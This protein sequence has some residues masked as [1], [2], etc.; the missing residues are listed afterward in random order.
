MPVMCVHVG[1]VQQ[2]HMRVQ[3]YVARGEPV[4]VTSV[5]VSPVTLVS[6]CN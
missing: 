2:F 1:V 5:S 6:F 4:S 3:C